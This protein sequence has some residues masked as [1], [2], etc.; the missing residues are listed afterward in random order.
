M[1]VI[2]ELKLQKNKQRAN[3][4]LDNA[5]VCGLEL[6][7]IMKHHLKEGVEISREQLET[8]QVDS[9]LERAMDKALSLLERQKYT[10]KQIKTK[11]STKGYLPT[12]IDSV[13]QKLEEYGYI[14]D[15]DYAESFL[16][17][18][19]TKS[20]KEIRFSL[21]QKGIKEDIINNVLE[22]SDFDEEDTI[23]RLADK[24][25]RY[26][27]PSIEN[28]KKL[29]AYLYRKGFDYSQITK[30]ASNYDIEIDD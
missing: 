13:I 8:M 27:E 4:Y 2:T 16:K 9:E 20:K 12:V 25:M 22:N 10:K 19:S 5:F 3:V 29:V 7:T 17:S 1:A 11:L 6:A 21:M 23:T 30:I 26:K 28:K 18:T 14:S 15:T 24:F